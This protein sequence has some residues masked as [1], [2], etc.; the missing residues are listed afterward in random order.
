MVDNKFNFSYIDF[1]QIQLFGLEI[2]ANEKWEIKL[3][4]K[5]EWLKFLDGND[6]FMRAGFRPPI[7]P[8]EVLIWKWSTFRIYNQSW[9]MMTIEVTET[10]NKKYSI[11]VFRKKP[12]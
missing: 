9:L 6:P 7:I 12:E 5:N 2:W 1:D 3:S 4:G 11:Q 10:S 8:N